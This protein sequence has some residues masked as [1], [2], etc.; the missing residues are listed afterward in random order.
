MNGT[1]YRSLQQ[2]LNTIIDLME[3][4]KLIKN[5]F[6]AVAFASGGG[7]EVSVGLQC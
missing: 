4:Q 3:L 6:K 2:E 7:P 5:L 1:E